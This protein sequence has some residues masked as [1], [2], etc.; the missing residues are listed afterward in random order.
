[1]RDV[2]SPAWGSFYG[3]GYFQWSRRKVVFY[4]VR[5]SNY[6]TGTPDHAPFPARTV[7]GRLVARLGGTSR[8]TDCSKR[9]TPLARN[10]GVAFLAYVVATARARKVH[11][12]NVH[13]MLIATPQ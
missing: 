6:D 2:S 1:M 7:C 4:Y 9:D 12:C 3:Y 10:R 13:I 5:R 11:G 8:V